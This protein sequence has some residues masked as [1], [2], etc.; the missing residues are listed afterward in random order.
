M[1]PEQYRNLGILSFTFTLI[2][3]FIA[4]SLLFCELELSQIGIVL[5]HNGY[6]YPIYNLTNNSILH[7]II[8]LISLLLTLCFSFG[9]IYFISWY[10]DYRKRS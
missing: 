5:A 2:L 7:K 4:Y 10:L 1:F 8:G 9:S 6:I 3:G